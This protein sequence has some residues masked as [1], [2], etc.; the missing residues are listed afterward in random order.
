MALVLVRC[1]AWPPALMP[2]VWGPEASCFV[3]HSC[4]GALI[5]LRS[6]QWQ[7]GTWIHGSESHIMFLSVVPCSFYWNSSCGREFHRRALWK[8]L[9]P[10]NSSTFWKS[11]LCLFECPLALDLRERAMILQQMMFLEY[12]PRLGTRC[13]GDSSR[14]QLESSPLVGNTE[15]LCVPHSQWQPCV[16]AQAMLLSSTR[17]E[18]K[19]KSG[20]KPG[21]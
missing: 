10:Q 14:A 5:L 12:I 19:E 11:S 8:M 3:G 6:C 16:G 17:G 20:Q 7:L 1:P 9:C 13:C 2:N 18:K 21:I 4:A 15:W